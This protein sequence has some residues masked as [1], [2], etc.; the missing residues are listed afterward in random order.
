MGVVLFRIDDRLIHGQVVEG[1]FHHLRPDRVVVA[2]DETAAS[3]F[4]QTLMGLVVP[5]GVQIE[6]LT[7][8]EAVSRCLEGAYSTCRAIV[9]F[10]L[11]QDVSTAIDLGLQVDSLN[12]GGLHATGKTKFLCRGVSASESD[13]HVLKT[14][15]DSGVQVEVRPVPSETGLDLR[16]LM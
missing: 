5:Y 12:L 6:I 16:D 2:D 4:Q 11:P 8:R 9:L 10:R 14:I 1:W 13:L 3:T 7:V 15:L